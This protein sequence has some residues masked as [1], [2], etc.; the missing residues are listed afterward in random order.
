MP[1]A[2]CKRCGLDW[3][4]IVPKP[5]VCPRCKSYRWETAAKKPGSE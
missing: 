3:Q 5:R 1:S 2:T 4:P